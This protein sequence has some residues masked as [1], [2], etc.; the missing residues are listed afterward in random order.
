MLMEGL[1]IKL[2]AVWDESVK[3][4]MQAHIW[5]S[6]KAVYLRKQSCSSHPHLETWSFSGTAGFRGTLCQTV[7]LHPHRRDGCCSPSW[8]WRE[9]G[10]EPLFLKALR[11][12]LTPLLCRLSSSINT[13]RRVSMKP[14]TNAPRDRWVSTSPTLTSWCLLSSTELLSPALTVLYWW[15]WCERAVPH[16]FTC[17]CVG[18]CLCTVYLLE[19]AC[20]FSSCVCVFL[21]VFIIL[22]CLYLHVCV[23]FFF[24]CLHVCF[25]Q[26]F[27][28]LCL[29]VCT[30]V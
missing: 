13:K 18:V 10:S 2:V 29:L 11:V 17:V 22:L 30:H 7:Q 20:V 24:L 3:M 14:R 4:H 1:L 12:R 23:F 27:V 25:L 5:K 9:C 19:C 26:L 8:T 28:C 21:F 15:T 6:A 16:L